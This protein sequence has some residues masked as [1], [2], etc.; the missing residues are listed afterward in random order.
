MRVSRGLLRTSLY[1]ALR[2]VLGNCSC[3]ALPPASMQSCGRS[4]S[5][6][7]ILSNRLRP[8]SRPVLANTISKKSPLKAGY[9]MNMASPRGLLRT[10]LYYALRAVLRTFKFVPNK[11]VELA[12]PGSNP[13]LRKTIT[14]K[15]RGLQPPSLCIMASPRGFEP[16]INYY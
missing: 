6:Q 13:G 7:M 1:Y 5:F 2:A 11:L 16:V 14:P 10:S 4:K 8:G 9:F 3:I 15:K 12:T